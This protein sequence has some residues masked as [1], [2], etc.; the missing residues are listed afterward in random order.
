MSQQI[1]RLRRK[2]QL[3]VS[4]RLKDRTCTTP[5]MSSSIALV[6]TC[7]LSDQPELQERGRSMPA[8]PSRLLAGA[9]HLN[10]MRDYRQWEIDQGIPRHRR[11]RASELT[12]K[13]MDASDTLITSLLQRREFKAEN[14]DGPESIVERAIENAKRGVAPC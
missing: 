10:R 6:R 13:T 8:S 9:R 1:A 4:V 7:Q 12:A 11:I 14:P 2:M 3:M 5:L